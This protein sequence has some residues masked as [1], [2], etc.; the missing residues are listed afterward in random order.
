MEFTQ[1]FFEHQ[2]MQA[3]GR[4]LFPSCIGKVT[5]EGRGGDSLATGHPTYRF[6]GISVRKAYNRLR[7]S[8]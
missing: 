2:T 4:L 1:N 6:G 8:G 7:Y 5:Q 3:C